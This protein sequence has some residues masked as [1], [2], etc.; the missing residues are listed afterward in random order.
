MNY[1]ILKGIENKKAFEIME[2]VRKNRDLTEDDLK[3]MYDHGVPQWYVDSCIKIKY[4]F[5]R[6]HAVA[7]VMMS[8]RMAW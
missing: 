2:K 3:T 1:L 8:M 5:P 4:M 7:Y 6:A